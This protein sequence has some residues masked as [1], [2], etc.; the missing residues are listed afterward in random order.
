MLD[1]FHAI[2]AT[3]V[4]ALL[5]LVVASSVILVAACGNPTTSSTPTA[6]PGGPLTSCSI[7]SSDIAPTTTSSGTATK[8]SGVSGKINVDGSSALA[9]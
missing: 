3:G 7:S 8:V 1:R 6:T 5:G 4:R 9:P 2:R